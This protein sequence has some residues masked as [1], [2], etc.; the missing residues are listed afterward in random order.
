MLRKMIFSRKLLAGFSLIEII[1]VLLIIS[2]LGAIAVPLY[3]NEKSRS[4]LA[5]AISDS[6]LLGVEVAQ[7]LADYTSLG[8]GAGSISLSGGVLV[9]SAMTGATGAGNVLATGPGTTASVVAISAKSVIGSSNWSVSGGV[10][11]CLE[12]TNLGTYAK[13]TDAGPGVSGIGTPSGSQLCVA[14]Y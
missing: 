3:V 5:A 14:G 11:W 10:H 4:Y 6:N 1:V 13:I 9:F 2:V 12:I 8:T 7:S